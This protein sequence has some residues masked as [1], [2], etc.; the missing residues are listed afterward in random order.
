MDIYKVDLNL[1]R[2]FHAVAE[3]NSLTLAGQ[4]L[5]LSQPAVSYSLGRLRAMFNDPLFIRAG[6]AM[7]ATPVA[8]ELL[9]PIQSAM[10][11]L[12][13]ALSYGE[14]F[15]PKQSKRTFRL[16]MSDLG[17]MTFLPALCEKLGQLAPHIYLEVLNFPMSQIADNLRSGQLDFAIGNL[18]SLKDITNYASLF[19]E[20]YV[21]MTN[22][23]NQLNQYKLSIE[24]FLAKK[25]ILVASIENNHKQVE[26]YLRD[27][28]IRRTIALQVPHFS[29]VPQI[30]SRTDWMVTLPKRAAKSLNLGRKFAIYNLPAT[31][32]DVEV[33]VHWHEDFQNNEASIWF[34]N[35]L[36]STLSDANLNDPKE[37][38]A[39]Q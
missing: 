2:V 30:L 37:F 25:H 15:S 31:I 9:M 22:K 7:K 19:H 14:Q 1:L 21:C 10:L 33:T 27:L 18:A 29:V 32:P 39:V 23:Q 5:G 26:Q 8:L 16:A 34:R 11:H 12:Q 35:L 36:I 24:D 20:A 13:S 17:E 4:R 6:N 28:N 3:E 38:L